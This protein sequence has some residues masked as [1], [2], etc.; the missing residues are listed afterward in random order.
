M[1]VYNHYYMDHKLKP[2]AWHSPVPACKG[3]GTLGISLD[4]ISV[5]LVPQNLLVASSSSACSFITSQ[6]QIRGCLDMCNPGDKMLMGEG[7][8]RVC[9]E[10]ELRKS[11][12]V[13]K[14]NSNHNLKVASDSIMSVVLYILS[15]SRHLII[16]LLVANVI[17]CEAAM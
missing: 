8:G 12:A 17:I 7:R 13:T 9:G 11:T 2:G 10:E 5:W 6:Q 15:T 16:L 4:I 14:T 3:P 1:H